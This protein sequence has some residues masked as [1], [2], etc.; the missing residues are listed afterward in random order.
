MP[1][2]WV[3]LSDT[4]EK[5]HC[6]GRLSI[7]GETD[8]PAPQFVNWGKLSIFTL[9]VCMRASVAKNPSTWKL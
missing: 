9:E 1:G 6:D 3:D 4:I 7:S 8:S 5:R 2:S